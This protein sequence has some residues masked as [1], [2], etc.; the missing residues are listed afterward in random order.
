[1]LPNIITAIVA[2]VYFLH[3]FPH[4]LHAPFHSNLT[5]L[6]RE[7]CGCGLNE[8]VIYRF[9]KSNTDK[10]IDLCEWFDTCL[11]LNL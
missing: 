11:S 5:E 10:L 7:M 1:M 9:D 4:L 3:L 2:L 8:A 6:L